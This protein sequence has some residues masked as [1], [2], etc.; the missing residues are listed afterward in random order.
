MKKTW[1]AVAIGFGLALAPVLAIGPALADGELHIFNWGDY[2]SPDMIKKFEQ[3]YNVKVTLTDYD[4]NDAMLAKVKAGGSG[5]DIVVPSSYV[6]PSMVSDGLLAKTEPNTMENFKNMRPEF[7]HV[8]WDDGRHYT[9]PWQ[10]GTTGISVDTAKY[11][12]DINTWALL[13]DT[14]DELKGKVNVVPE[15]ADVINA[16]SFYIGKEP[17]SSDKE[18]LK[19]INDVLVAAKP[20]WRAMEYDT[21]GNMTAH[22]F[23]ATMDWNGASM[24]ER[25]ATGSVKYSYP[26]EG[27]ASWMDN[28]AVLK[29]APNMENAKLFQNFI[30][31]PE[32]AAMISAFARYDNG[33]AGT[34]KFLPKDMIGAPEITPPAGFKEIFVPACPQDV[35]EMYQKIWNNVMK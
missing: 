12:G 2:T 27:M 35:A 9:V 11:K 16:V 34:E 20:N 15:M 22:N 24:R 26:K 25:I 4:S 5:F 21:V 19:K 18:T 29:D 10:W 30:M 31:D 28:V 23:S 32:N 17:C 1:T 8:Y 33:I 14:P 6:I 13:F 7:V 3:K